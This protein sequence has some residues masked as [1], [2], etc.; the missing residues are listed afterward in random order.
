MTVSSERIIELA[1]ECLGTPYRHQGR[2]PGIAL[3]CIGVPVYIAKQLG[4]EFWEQIGYSPTPDGTLEGILN[5]QPCLERIDAAELGA[6]AVLSYGEPHHVGIITDIGLLHAY[7]RS[8]RV[9]EHGLDDYWKS[10][11]THYY[12][13]K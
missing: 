8:G 1:R 13:F 4:L 5:G 10:K 11:I 12:R 6:L 2:L 3:D 9:V 7:I